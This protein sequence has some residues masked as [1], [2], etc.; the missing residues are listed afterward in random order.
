MTAMKMRLAGITQA[1]GA[2][3]AVARRDNQIASRLK[4]TLARPAIAWAL[5]GLGILLRSAWY[6]QDQS[7]WFDELLLAFN[8]IDVPWTKVIAP[9][10]H[11]QAAPPVFLAIERLLVA[12]LGENELVLRLLPFGASVGALVLCYYLARR[13]LPAHVVPFAILLFAVLRPLSSFGAELKPYSV[14]VAVAVGLT[15]LALRARAEGRSVWSLAL[16]FSGAISVWL[17]YPAAF[18]LVG[19]GAVLIA[20]HVA[21]RDRRGATLYVLVSALWQVSFASAYVLVY[22][23]TRGNDFLSDYWAGHFMPLPPTG[24]ADLQWF[25]DHFFH[26]FTHV[27]GPSVILLSWSR[28]S[29]PSNGSR[30]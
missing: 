19:I 20:E 22:A 26:L 16:G 2:E 23:R 5:I 9:L 18:V 11:N 14:D 8:I 12:L 30:P 13:L 21:R 25:I 4:E 28:R 29:V 15:L 10:A 27:A 6:L 17:S 1:S 7:L 24:F 3:A